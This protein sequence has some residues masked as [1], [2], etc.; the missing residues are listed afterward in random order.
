MTPVFLPRLEA[1]ASTTGLQ[2]AELLTR[3]GQ[4]DAQAFGRLYDKALKRLY[5]MA[6]RITR[7]DALA[8]DAVHD[9]MLEVWCKTDR[10]NPG[11]GNADAWLAT[12]VRYRALD[13]VRKQRRERTGIEMPEPVNE[14]PDALC[15]LIVAAEGAALRAC[16]DEVELPNRRLVLLAFVDGLSHREIAAHM[17]Q[18]LGTVKSSIRHTLLALR[19]QLERAVGSVFS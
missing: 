17:G 15:H 3:C 14:A 9:A 18:P 7:V 11:R 4:G 10:Y 12:L 19:P 8:S 2:T 5:R 16:L 1:F 6:L 13:I